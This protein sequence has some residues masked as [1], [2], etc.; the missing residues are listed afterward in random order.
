MPR[1]AIPFTL[2]T[3]VLF[4]AALTFG[5]F[6]L[7][8]Q[9]TL[10]SSSQTSDDARAI[11]SRLSSFLSDSSSR[12][13]RSAAT[14]NDTHNKDK[15]DQA[16]KKCNRTVKP[17]PVNLCNRSTEDVEEHHGGL[18]VINL[19]WAQ[20][21]LPLVIT[22]FLLLTSLLKIGFHHADFLSTI[23]PESC[24]LIILGVTAGGLIKL[25]TTYNPCLK[26]DYLAF[27]TDTFF[28]Y[29]LPPIMLESAYSLHDR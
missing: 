28:F 1:F 6:C 13:R 21:E 9:V 23:L 26:A 4:L 5:L 2:H 10:P 8:T 27:N 16:P 14:T 3:T 20:V 12:Y 19:N 11:R 17:A 22:V 18:H 29:L 15:H 25:A 7:L 24:V